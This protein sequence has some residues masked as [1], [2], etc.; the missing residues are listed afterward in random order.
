MDIWAR[1]FGRNGDPEMKRALTTL[2]NLYRSMRHP[3]TGAMSW[4]TDKGV[5]RR[6]IS[7][8]LHNL[9]M[10]TTLQD[11]A[12]FVEERDKELAG[13]MREFV[14]GI[15]DE[16]LSN[17]YDKILDVAGKGILTWYT[18]ADR[19]VDS[20][21]PPANVKDPS[22]GFPLKTR[23]GRPAASVGYLTPWFPNRSYAGISLMLLDRYERCEDKHKPLYR[24]AVLESANIYM[25]I[26]PEIQFATYPDE[27]AHVAK[28][29]RRCY[30]LTKNPAYLRRANHMMQLGIKLFFDDVSPL[31]KISNLDDWYES[32]TKNASSQEIFY[33]MVELTHDL[34][35]L[36]SKERHTPQVTLR[37]ALNFDAP[38]SV[39][40]YPPAK[41][42][43]DLKAAAAEKMGG[44]WDGSGL[45]RKSKDVALAYGG[46]SAERVLYLSQEKGVFTAKKQTAAAFDISISD[47]IN[48]I[49]TVAEADAANGGKM[50]RLTG[51]G[52]EKDGT[53]YAGF[54]DVLKSC[55]LLI[56]N[57]SRKEQVVV[58]TATFHDNYHDNGT[59]TI[60][61]TVPAKGTLFFAVKAPSRKYIRKLRVHSTNGSPV[62]ID[63]IGFV[64]KKRNAL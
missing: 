23:D 34:K 8:V 18:T 60:T 10:A 3:K 11:A 57:D 45:K 24:R 5:G 49:P 31:P 17:D 39:G 16:Y 25:T 50:P 40:E 64:M 52:M 15:D 29:L 20:A 47:V 4:C 2:L 54:K 22:I 33:Q 36:S 44:V 9:D 12:V 62:S 14:M 51:K 59:E 6:E 58:M 55:G 27:I 1:E 61:G 48:K 19:R 26:E 53:T 46:K 7:A 28:L 21:P 56:H 43:T 32:S 35:K 42:M 30:G 41:F 13:A 38:D 37:E 63:N